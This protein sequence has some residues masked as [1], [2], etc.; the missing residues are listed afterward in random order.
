[1][2]KPMTILVSKDDIALSV[3]SFISLD[4]MRIG[5]LDISDP[6][7]QAGAKEANIQ[8]IDISGVETDD[9]FKH[10]GFAALAAIYPEMKKQG[11][12]GGDVLRLSQAGVFVFDAV[13]RTLTAPFALGSRLA[14]GR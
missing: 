1:M 4:Q 14:A 7:V 12:K 5:Q 10:N 9:T 13:G 8:F 2:K 6:R 11:D 3:S